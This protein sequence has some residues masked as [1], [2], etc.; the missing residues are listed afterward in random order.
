MIDMS[1]R[2][3]LTLPAAPSLPGMASRKSKK[4]LLV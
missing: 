3:L 4:Q 1:L 2:L